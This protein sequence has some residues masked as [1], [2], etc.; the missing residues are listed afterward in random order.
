MT[1]FPNPQ[2]R[3]DK[4]RASTA[5]TIFCL[6]TSIAPSSATLSKQTKRKLDYKQV[7]AYGAVAGVLN[8]LVSTEIASDYASIVKGTNP[9]SGD[10]SNARRDVLKLVDARINQELASREY[11]RAALMALDDLD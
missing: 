11:M 6:A 4:M 7:A 8:M 9:H 2:F 5:V 10:S 3:H 1:F